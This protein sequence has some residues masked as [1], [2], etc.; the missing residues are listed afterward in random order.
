MVAKRKSSGAPIRAHRRGRIL[1]DDDDERPKLALN[2]HVAVRRGRDELVGIIVRFDSGYVVV[3]RTHK[4]WADAPLLYADEDDVRPL[5]LGP[6]RGQ[7]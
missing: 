6:N 5:I 2:Q 7:F 1:K 3:R 4:E